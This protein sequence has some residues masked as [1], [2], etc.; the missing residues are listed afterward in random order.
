MKYISKFF[1]A[2]LASFVLIANAF[3]AKTEPSYGVI[4]LDP[5]LGS[6]ASVVNI[7]NKTY[8]TF[9]CRGTYISSGRY[10]PMPLGPYGSPTAIVSFPISGV[11][12]EYAINMVVVRNATGQIIF[13]HNLS[14]G[15]WD[16]VY[17]A[18][19]TVVFEP[20]H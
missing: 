5:K 13:S 4:Q 14:S 11:D 10:F 19:N 12:P 15:D 1:L 18:K 7:Y 17:S 3:A 16:I 6:K 9:T 20:H 8:E 2:L